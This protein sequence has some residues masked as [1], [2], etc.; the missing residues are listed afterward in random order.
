MLT[1]LLIVFPVLLFMGHPVGFSMAVSSVIAVAVG[2]SV[3]LTIVPQKMAGGLD[4]FTLLAV[5]FFLLA[6]ELM[7][8]GGLTTRLIRFATCLVGHLK[9]GMMHVSILASLIFAG[10]SGSAVADASAIGAITIRAMIRKGYDPAYVAAVQAGAAA[11]GPIFPPSIIMIVW[12]SMTSLSVAAM[13]LG[14][15]IPGILIAIG[16]MIY[17]HFYSIRA[18][19]G[20]EARAR[21][22][23][24]GESTVQAL[25]ALVMPMIIL[26]GIVSGVF[27]PTE[28]GCV[29]AMYA[30]FAGAFIY[31]ELKFHDLEG[32]FLRATASGSMVMLIVAA[33][34]MY[35][36]VLTIEQF[37]DLVVSWM[38][39]HTTSPPVVLAL[40]ILLLLVVGCFIDVLAAAIILIPVLNPIALKFGFDPIHF[41][42]V[43]CM[44][45]TVG[46]VTPPVGVVLYVTTNLANVTLSQS[47]RK[48]LLP[49]LVMVI[50]CVLCAYI[51]ELITAIP[52]WL[53]PKAFFRG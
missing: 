8:A 43:M 22:R 3:P 4:N 51:P 47:S 44:T 53:L 19:Y 13:F 35:G 26:G 25:P 36:W 6:G 50:V 46:V 28:A 11:I 1:T 14:G 37:P 21:L 16:L 24:L 40:L 7:E 32:V 2:G 29:S 9:G 15:V 5:P 30:A 10:I 12:A 23:E 48:A 27:T 17:N 39:S 31:K 52:R 18:G 41:A 38:L 45:L 33:S 34:T 42:V 49:V 20:G